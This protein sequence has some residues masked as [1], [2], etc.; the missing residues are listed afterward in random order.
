MT[1]REIWSVVLGYKTCA[2]GF[3]GYFFSLLPS[4][5]FL[6]MFELKKQQLCPIFTLINACDNFT[7]FG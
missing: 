3:L 5:F 7:Y 4:A 6:D 1:R 2:E